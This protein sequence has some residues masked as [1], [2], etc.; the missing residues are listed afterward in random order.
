MVIIS[1]SGAFSWQPEFRFPNSL[2]V[3]LADLAISCQ[4]ILAK[5][6]NHYCPDL[7]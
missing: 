2:K 4:S 6:E 1:S 7:P 5:E 3:F